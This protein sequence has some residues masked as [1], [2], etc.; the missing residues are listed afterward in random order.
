MNGNLVFDFGGVLFRWVPH[1][2]LQRL[3]PAR[4]TDEAAARRLAHD[5]FQSFGG[6]WADF[7]RGAVDAPQ[8]ADR[9]ARRTGLPRAEVDAVIAAVP[10]ELTPLPDTLALLSRLHDRGHR[11]F[12]LSNMPAPYAGHLLAA[13]PFLR[14]FEAGVFSSQVRLIKPEP[15]IYTVAANHFGVAPRELLF[16]DDVRHNVDAARGAGWQAVHF[17]GA[18]GLEAFLIEAGAL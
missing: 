11:L 1:D 8:V 6:D 12:Y 4:A 16:I 2:F 7:D 15:A 10:H 9:I 18:A 13:H 14:R 3:L 17:E 5:V